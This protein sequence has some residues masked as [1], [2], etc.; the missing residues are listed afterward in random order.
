MSAAKWQPFGQLLSPVRDSARVLRLPLKLGL[1][2]ASVL[3][4]LAR[5]P[6]ELPVVV[7]NLVDF[8][9]RVLCLFFAGAERG[10]RDLQILLN[11]RREWMRAAEHAPRDPPRVHERRHG[12]A[13]IVGRGAGV[14]V[15][16]IRVN[17][18][19]PERDL[20]SLSQNAWRHANNFAQQ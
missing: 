2:H 19:H 18:P 7:M 15:E 16:H 10:S 5:R 17:P 14:H 1:G 3:Q 12:L 8:R 13:E 11:P 20:M 6:V 4:P 9:C